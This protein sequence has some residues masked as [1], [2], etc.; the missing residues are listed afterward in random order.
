MKKKRR[1]DDANICIRILWTVAAEAPRCR[2]LE[3]RT[4][5]QLI[6]CSPTSASWKQ[7]GL[8]GRKPPQWCVLIKRMCKKT[9]L[10]STFN[11]SYD[12]S[13]GLPGPD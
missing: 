10:L 2:I 12:A 3:E 9:D 4:V 11:S 13:D 6:E 8:G 7:G 1:L 5:P